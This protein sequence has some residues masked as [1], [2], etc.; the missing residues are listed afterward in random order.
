MNTRLE[1]W[2]AAAW[3]DYEAG[4]EE[5]FSNLSEEVPGIF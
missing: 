3:A 4:Q 5:A 1:I 2:D